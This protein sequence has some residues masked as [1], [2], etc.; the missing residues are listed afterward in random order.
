LK[1]LVFKSPVFQSAI[2][3]VADGHFCFKA[4][5]AGAGLVTIGGVSLDEDSLHATRE[6]I[7][8]GRKEFYFEIDEREEFLKENIRV[9]KKGGSPVA[10][11]VRVCSFKGLLEAGK[12]VEACGADI[13]ELNAHCRQPEIISRGG[14]QEL[15][16]NPN[17]LKDWLL[18][19]REEI[20][21][22]VSVKI[23]ANVGNTLKIV[24]MLSEIPVDII[25]ID[26]MVPGEPRADLQLLREVC[27]SVDMFVIGNNSVTDGISAYRMLNT[28]VNAVSVARA[29]MA[30][31]SAISKIID[32]LKQILGER[33]RPIVLHPD[34]G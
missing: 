26:A 9:A 28:G 7:A 18:A 4:A 1:R 22:P 32:E 5:V 24:K 6:I 23:R 15:L 31:P 11:N 8:R 17:K 27:K 19:I 3:G 34:S 20:Q 12:I 33:L 14:G 30:S 21:I 13:F 2:A 16:K 10:V 29:I 25:H